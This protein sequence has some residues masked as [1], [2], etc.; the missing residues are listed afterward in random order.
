MENKPYFLKDGLSEIFKNLSYRE[1]R[2]EL[3]RIGNDYRNSPSEIGRKVYDQYAGM[4]IETRDPREISR[5]EKLWSKEKEATEGY[6][7]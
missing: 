2:K 3:V 7:I 5:L 1:T 6:T 4:I